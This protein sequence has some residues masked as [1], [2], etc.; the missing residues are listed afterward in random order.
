[1]PSMSQ[2]TTFMAI[3]GP[4]FLT[5]VEQIVNE[6]VLKNYLLGRFLRGADMAR[7]LQGGTDIRD[8][9]MF[10]EQSTAGFYSPNAVFAETN[11]QVITNWKAYWRFYKDAMVW[12]DQEIELQ[13]PEGMGTPMRHQIYK[14]IKWQKEQRLWTS[15]LNGMER[16]LFSVPV[17]ANMEAETGQEAFSIP[18]FLNEWTDAL[19]F[20][21]TGG[22]AAGTAWTTKQNIDPTIETRWKPALNIPLP[23]DG[24]FATLISANNLLYD[25]TAT[26]GTTGTAYVITTRGLLETFDLAWAH[27]QFMPPPTRTEYFENDTMFR[28]VILC[29]FAGQTFYMQKLRQSQDVFATPSRQDPAFVQPQYANIDVLRV[30]QLDLAAIYPNATPGSALQTESS[31]TA[32]DIGARYY[33]VN[34][35]Y[36]CP[37]F[38]AR[39]YFEKTAP[40]THRDQPFTH[41]QYVDTW[42]NLIARSLQRHALVHPKGLV[43]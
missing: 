25:P 14:R 10:D 15:K 27:T 12:T 28:Q 17:A 5:G 9:V 39:R 43:A 3:T 42:Y 11:P 36:L 21:R 35:T 18:A 32:E 16:S 22:D 38:H 7:T 8:S 1:M 24:H 6:A 26:Y 30:N 4:S 34:G 2:F 29:S 20:K 19:F 41:V 37:V 31:A 13:V 23:A 40:M 33:F